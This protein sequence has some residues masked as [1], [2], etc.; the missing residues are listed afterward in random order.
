[1]G[2][3]LATYGFNILPGESKEGPE[4]ERLLL[5]EYT[6]NDIQQYLTEYLTYFKY[7]DNFS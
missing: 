6:S 7:F 5:L 4:F 2:T 3:R 1:M